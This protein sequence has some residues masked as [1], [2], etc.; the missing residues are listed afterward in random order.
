MSEF[1]GEYSAG[2]KTESGQLVAA[3]NGTGIITVVDT[4]LDEYQAGYLCRVHD[5]SEGQ[6]TWLD[7]VHV[8]LQAA[9]EADGGWDLWV[10]KRYFLKPMRGV[11]K[12]VYG[13]SLIL[14]SENL[15]FALEQLRRVTQAAAKEMGL[16]F[17]LESMPLPHVK[18]RDRNAPTEK[19]KGAAPVGAAPAI[20]RRR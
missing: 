14:T 1:D 8:L 18:D 10:A 2:F 13:W 17:E 5:D 7:L 15:G 20:T 12:L 3:L 16:R 4:D 9:V 6:Q 11:Q 19:G